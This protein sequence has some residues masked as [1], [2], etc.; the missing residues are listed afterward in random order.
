MKK[1]VI[2]VIIIICAWTAFQKGM[3]SGKE[4]KKQEDYKKIEQVQTAMEKLAKTSATAAF[5]NENQWYV[6]DVRMMKEEG[7]GDHAFYQALKAELGEDFDSQLSNGD[8]IFAGVMP[9]L[10]SYR[11]YAGNP[12]SE[13]NMI[14]PDWN[15]SKLQSKE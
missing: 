8:Y 11:I 10:G 6:F 14:Y 15:Y 12:E 4:K 7:S 1:I 3:E 5:G 2:L 13:E 9:H